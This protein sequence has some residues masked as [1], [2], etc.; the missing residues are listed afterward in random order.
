M[1]KE[2]NSIMSECSR[3]TS[4]EIFICLG[5]YLESIQ[6]GT[7]ERRAVCSKMYAS[8]NSKAQLIREWQTIVYEMRISEAKAA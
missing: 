6:S 2:L 7:Y 4:D 8:A 5:R 1:L 3:R